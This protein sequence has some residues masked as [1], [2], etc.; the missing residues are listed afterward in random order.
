MVQCRAMENKTKETEHKKEGRK[1]TFFDVILFPFKLLRIIFS[2]IKTGMRIVSIVTL[3]FFIWF[4]YNFYIIFSNLE[5]SGVER[6]EAAIEA[7]TITLNKTKKRFNDVYEN[8]PSFS[9]FSNE[10]SDKGNIRDTFIKTR[11]IPEAYVIMISYD[12]IKNE[13]PIKRSE[14]L[15]FEIWFYGDS[16]N[17]KVSF[18]NGF[19]KERKEIVATNEFIENS[20][21]PL[22]FDTD[23]TK[24]KVQSVF[25]LPACII[26][27]KAGDDTL[28]TYRFKET[29]TTPLT[30]ITFVNEEII[31]VSSGIVFLGDNEDSLCK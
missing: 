9:F 26:T 31:A 1:I 13:V 23:T 20:I 30:A 27:E 21:S 5:E 7:F 3:I 4:G 10:Y 22:F 25:G 19:F 12:E 18:E 17:E 2:F 29:A 14:P 16:Y 28:T 6:E 15:R 24:K 8:I 11:G